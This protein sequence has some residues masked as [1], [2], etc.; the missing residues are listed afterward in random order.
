[1]KLNCVNLAGVLLLAG[2]CVAQWRRDREL[3]L[4]VNQLQQARHEQAARLAE[5][6]ASLQSA[7]ADLAQFKERLGRSE[8]D[9]KDAH[10][11]RQRA[12]SDVREL[13]AE[14]D[15][16]KGSVTNWAAALRARD[17]RL[18]EAGAQARRLSD[19]LLAA[20]S[21]FNTLATSHNAVVKELNELRARGPRP[22]PARTQ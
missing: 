8:T 2:L 18:Q 3:N 21:R 19:D 12:E 14:R 16:L 11:Q 15:Q 4:E 20:I 22:D 13:A 7:N 5:L 17:E 6:E 1:M 9:L 10:R